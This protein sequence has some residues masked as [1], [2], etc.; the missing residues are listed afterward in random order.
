MVFLTAKIPAAEPDLISEVPAATVVEPETEEVVRNRTQ[1][2]YRDP[3]PPVVQGIDGLRSSGSRPRSI[4]PANRR[5][6]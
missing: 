2:I 3:L 4:A 6:P 1:L 5:Q